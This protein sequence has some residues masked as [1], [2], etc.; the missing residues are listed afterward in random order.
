MNRK[1]SNR[2]VLLAVPAVLNVVLALAIVLTT[3]A[4]LLAVAIT[5]LGLVWIAVPAM[6]M[7]PFEFEGILPREVAAVSALVAMFAGLG[8]A[9]G[10]MIVGVVAE[11]S[12]S[13]LTGLVVMAVCS[14]VGVIAGLL[15]PGSRGG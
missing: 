3:D 11:V 4:V 9:A 5:A 1:L 14:A 2:R 8:F 15:Y 7:L 13:L 12:G 10:P 6:E